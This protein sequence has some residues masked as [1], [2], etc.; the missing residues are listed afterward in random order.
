MRYI[1]SCTRISAMTS[2]NLVKSNFVFESGIQFESEITISLCLYLNSPIIEKMLIKWLR[3][4]KSSDS[5]FPLETTP[6][7]RFAYYNLIALKKVVNGSSIYM[8]I[9]KGLIYTVFYPPTLKFNGKAA[10]WSLSTSEC[11]Q[12]KWSGVSQ[13][14]FIWNL[15]KYWLVN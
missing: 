7:V 15:F 5:D 12:Q 4:N 8:H 6:L 10:N 3:I 1:M 11:L 13:L 14:T 9:S 2:A